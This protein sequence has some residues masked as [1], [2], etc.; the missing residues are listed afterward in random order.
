MARKSQRA[1]PLVLALAGQAGR[2]LARQRLDGLADVR[3]LLTAGMHEVDV[4]G[5]RLAQGLRH[6]LDAA[7][8]HK[9]APDLGFDSRA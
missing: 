6:R 2:Q 5:Q 4:L 9:A 7:V 1:P 3:H 8:S